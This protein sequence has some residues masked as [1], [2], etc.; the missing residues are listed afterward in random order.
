LTAPLVK[1]GQSLGMQ[2]IPWTVN[3][4]DAME[5]LVD[6][7]VDGIISHYPDRLRKVMERKG[8]PL[9]RPPS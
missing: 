2:V 8:I 7:G 5:K 4:E 1:V 9:P 3:D 6:W